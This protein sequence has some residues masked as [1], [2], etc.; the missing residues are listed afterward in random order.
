MLKDR[1]V[2]MDGRFIP[3]EDANVHIMSHS[4]ARG[5]GIFEV[6]GVHRT[7]AGTAVFRLDE[8]VSRFFRSAELLEMNL[9]ISADDLHEA[10]L[11][12]VRRNGLE[13]GV[14]K[15][16]GFYPQ[17]AFDI[18]PPAGNLSVAVFA[19]DP[20]V[21]LGSSMF[22]FDR[23][24]TTCISSWR[25]IHP[26]TVPPEA[27][28]AANYLNGMMSRLD[29][30]KKG[31]EMA[32][33]LDNEGFIAEGGT[34]SVFI[35]KDGKLYTPALGKILRSI[36]RKS[37]PVVAAS[38]GIETVETQLKPEALYDADEVFFSCT[39]MKVCPVSRIDDRVFD[40][41]PGPMCRRLRDLMNRV[42]AGEDERFRGWLFQ[43]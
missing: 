11:E 25:K 33:M 14:V 1:V 36:S 29:A 23:G 9:A 19:V 41:V 3:W 2:Y 38:E 5:S 40:Q 42:T 37:V 21:D 12:T 18:M 15:I 22:S 28:V 30:R 31:F 27:K 34:E 6:L 24:V 7:Q 10:V 20:G 43:V 39:V 13:A 32:V 8:Y 17:V 26:G 16:M 4:F 35:V